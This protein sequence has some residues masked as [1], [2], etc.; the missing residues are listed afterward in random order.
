MITK[1]AQQ[2]QHLYW[3]LCNFMNFNK[4]KFAFTGKI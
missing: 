1:M 3:E 4:Y 2:T